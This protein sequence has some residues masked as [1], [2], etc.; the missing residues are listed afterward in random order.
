MTVNNLLTILQT[1]DEKNQARHCG[2]G[3]GGHTSVLTPA[4]K[5]EK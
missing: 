1:D 2:G 4:S 5:K 3:R